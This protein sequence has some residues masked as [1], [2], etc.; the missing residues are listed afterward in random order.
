[1]AVDRNQ[2]KAPVLPQ[3]VVPV[4][5][6]GGDVIVRGLL[7]SQQMAIAAQTLLAGAPQEGESDEAAQ[8]RAKSLRV[9]ETLA[10]TVVLDDGKPLWT[11]GQWDVFGCQHPGVALQLFNTAQRLN[12][13]D[14][15]ASVKN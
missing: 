4:E 12:G 13:Q 2:T 7:M 5:P 8:I 6:L 10:R 9:A 3:E 14:E 15:E 11:A 1:M